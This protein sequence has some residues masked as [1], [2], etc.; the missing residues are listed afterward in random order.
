MQSTLSSYKKTTFLAFGIALASLLL[1]AILLLLR[2][3]AAT[4]LV[5][6]VAAGAAAVSAGGLIVLAR[7]RRL[8]AARPD[9]VM[10]LNAD[11]SEAALASA[12]PRPSA[13]RRAMARWL[14]G[15]DLV[16]GSRVRI[17]PLHEILATLDGDGTVERLPF[18]PEMLRFC[19]QEA[20]VFRCIDKIYDYR[21]SRRMRDLQGAVLLA[22]LRCDGAAHGGCQARC[23][24]IWKVQWLERLAPET[25][26]ATRA[27]AD[28]A[29]SD[30]GAPRLPGATERREPDGTVAYRCQFTELTAATE[31][32]Q[33]F[34]LRRWL[35]PWVAGNIT[36][37][38]FVVVLATRLFNW[39]QGLRGGAT[40]PPAPPRLSEPAEPPSPPL[41]P[42]EWVRVRPLEEIA[43]TLN[44]DSKHRGLW[45]DPDMVKHCG[46]RYRV[47]ARV[48]RIIDVVSGRM[49]TMRTPCIILDGV[50]YSGEYLQLSP[51]HEYLYWREVWLRRD[52]PPPGAAGAASQAAGAG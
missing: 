49:L 1:A 45:F 15:H 23:P 18:M 30:G 36:W 48:D 24:L 52:G 10:E 19:G 35:G 47:L 4:A 11:R 21:K 43:R 16:V 39:V 29:A 34:A 40:F 12:P 33:R 32:Q 2:V 22:G 6:L 5:A 25:P 3:P 42:G 46:Q 51:Q 13:W 26:K 37:T 44:Q 17:R 7:T 38:A 9:L 20:V 28:G 27:P 31:A 41:Q 8:L 14:L 50:D